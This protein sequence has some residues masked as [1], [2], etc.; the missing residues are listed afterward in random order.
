MLWQSWCPHCKSHRI[1][2]CF[3]HTLAGWVFALVAVQFRCD[4]CGLPCFKFRGVVPSCS[5]S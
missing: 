1:A 4:S 2:R 3:G 5:R